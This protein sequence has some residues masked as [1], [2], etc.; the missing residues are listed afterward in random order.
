MKPQVT[1]APAPVLLLPAS[2]WQLPLL[3]RLK[4]L[5][6]RP[7]IV[8]PTPGPEA[9]E[10]AEGV[11]R[12]DIFD[13][14]AVLA[15][16][17][18]AGVKAVISDQCDIAVPLVAEI[19]ETLGLPGIGS[20]QARLY[21]DKTAMRDFLRRHGMPHPEYLLCRGAEQARRFMAGLGR[22]VVVKPLN[23]NSSR[24]VSVVRTPE[25]MEQAFAGAQRFSRG[26]DA[27][28]VERYIDG[29]EF[30]VEGIKTPE[31]HHTLAVSRK[32]MFAHNGTVA[33]RLVYTATDEEFDYARLRAQ[34]D[35]YVELTGL[36]FGITHAEYRYED[37][38]FHLIEI[39]ARGA[40]NLVSSHVS[41]FMS[42]V[43]L[44][45]HLIAWSL[46]EP[47]AFPAL[48]PDPP[49]DRAAVLEFLS[50][51]Q[52]EGRVQALRGAEYLSRLDYVLAH[53]FNVKVGD[54]VSLPADDAARAGFYIA[55]APDRATLAERERH[56]RQEVAILLQ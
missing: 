41:P 36:P 46:G 30:T 13:V 48:P 19:A 20:E 9:L 23:A 52:C 47:T 25:R 3:R 44:Y 21:T 45:E 15:F 27:V 49:D 32:D 40:G 14:E 50:F 18:A 56:L 35:R 10:L 7:F 37:G 17:R 4:A 33:R 29:T 34:N 54:R 53:A 39:A 28:V 16:A 11:L 2:R 43:D 6:H 8:D 12:A 22:P 38:E 55:S 31:R 42:G 51:D 26:T 1:P 5:G 24:G